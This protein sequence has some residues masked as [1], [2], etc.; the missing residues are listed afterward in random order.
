M[1]ARDFVIP[2]TVAV[3]FAGLF[4]FERTMRPSS[5]E[6][7]LGRHT[8]ALVACSMTSGVTLHFVP[9]DQDGD[10]WRVSHSDPDGRIG[11]PGFVASSDLSACSLVMWSDDLA[12]LHRSQ[13]AAAQAPAY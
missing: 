7:W 10:V 6:Q 8:D 12:A 4:V 9:E 11:N 1:S 5:E 3:V 2:A 13:A